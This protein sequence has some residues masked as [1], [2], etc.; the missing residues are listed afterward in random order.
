MH[1][2]GSLES[3]GGLGQEGLRGM[4]NPDGL[5]GHQNSGGLGGQEGPEGW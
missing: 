2:P 5:G 1:G 3:P 4:G